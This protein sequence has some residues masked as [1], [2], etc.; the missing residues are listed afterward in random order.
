MIPIH[1]RSWLRA[2]RWLGSSLAE[3][4]REAPSP[5]RPLD[6]ARLRA[7]VWPAWRAPLFLLGTPAS[8]ADALARALG[9]LPGLSLHLRPRALREVC[10][11]ALLERWAPWRARLFLRM[12]CRWLQRV[13]LDGDQRPLVRSEDAGMVLPFLAGVFP[14]ARFVHLVRDGRTVA[15]LRA[16]GGDPLERPSW[17]LDRPLPDER[18][19]R[20]LALWQRSVAGVRFGLGHL[21]AHRWSELRCEDLAADRD[22]C[23]RLLAFLGLPSAAAEECREALAA[24]PSA[25]AQGP[26]SDEVREL[27]DQLGYTSAGHRPPPLLR[28]ARPPRGKRLPGPP[29][30]IFL[31]GVARS[32]TTLLQALLAAHP[33]IASFPESH[34]FQGVRAH[35]RWRRRLGL[36]GTRARFVFEGWLCYKLGRPDLAPEYGWST[37]RVR[38]YV[39]RFLD[40]ADRLAAEQGRG[41]WLEKSPGH[42]RCVPLIRAHVPDARVISIVRHGP[43][44]VA[45]LYHV[46]QRYKSFWARFELERCVEVW[47]RG[48]RIVRG[49]EGEPWHHGVRYERLVREPEAVLRELCAFLELPYRAEMLTGMAEASREVVTLREGWKSGVGRGVIRNTPSRFGEVFD[50]EQQA[51]VLAHLDPDPPFAARAREV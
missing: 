24:L 20:A 45:S 46:G 15:A 22:A 3:Q 6:L 43:D 48:R 2:A 4:V 12:S 26:V 37:V 23:A 11:A 10:A 35:D 33:D 9:R 40:V 21:P 28:R 47:N 50:A 32:G 34:I 29:R 14:D 27:L 41:A 42:L 16:R 30:R 18:R 13:G 1:P 36:A 38:D 19:A 39:R 7:S 17:W 49:L 8:G 44:Q 5:P 31:V 51:W 25:A